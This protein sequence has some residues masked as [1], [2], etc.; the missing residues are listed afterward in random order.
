LGIITFLHI[1]NDVL[2]RCGF[3]NQLIVGLFNLYGVSV[4]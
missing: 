1:G 2:P 3:K 4:F